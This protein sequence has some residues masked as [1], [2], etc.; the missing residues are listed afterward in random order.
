MKT[1]GGKIRNELQIESRSSLIVSAVKKCDPL[2]K[3]K[4]PD[5]AKK[6][7]LQMH[8]DFGQKDFYSTK[9]PDCGM[10]F[11]QGEAEDSKLHRKFHDEV[12]NGVPFVGSCRTFVY[13]CPGILVGKRRRWH[14]LRNC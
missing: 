3:K 10:F 5:Q 6:K 12:L 14:F 2:F 11:A 8:L 9:C 1:Y 4:S 7:L 13:E